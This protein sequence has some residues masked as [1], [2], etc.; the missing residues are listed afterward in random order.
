MLISRSKHKKS[1]DLRA[2]GRTLRDYR[3]EAGLSQEALAELA[4]THD[5]TISRIERGELNFSVTL[6][7]RICNALHASADRVLFTT[8]QP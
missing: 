1:L 2:V 5:R 4:D 3:K 8:E 6:L 7:Y